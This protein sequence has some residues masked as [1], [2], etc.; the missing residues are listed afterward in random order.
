MRLLFVKE[1]M[2]WPRSSGHDIRTFYLPQAM[3]RR[4]HAV[5]LATIVPPLREAVADGGFA[6]EYCFDD[7]T[8]PVPTAAAFPMNLSNMQEK[9]CGYW[10][11]DPERVRWAAAAVADFRA[12]AVVVVGLNGLPFLGALPTGVAKIWYAADE[13]VWH[14]LSQLRPLRKSTWGELK[15][16][17]IKG[18]YQR[19]YRKLLDRVW[20]VSPADAKA[21]RWFAGIRR[22]DVAPNG[23]D[24]EH[25]SPGFERQIPNSCVFWGR[26]DFGPNIQAVEWFVKHVWP[27]VR[28]AVPNATFQLY[29][30]QS[31]PGIQALAGRDGIALGMDLPDIRA[32]VRS[33]QVVVL[34]FVSG[35]GIKNKL[36]EA[37]ALGMPI[38]AARRVVAGLNGQPPISTARTPGDWAEQLVTL[39]QS[40]E[41]RQKLGRDARAWVTEHHTWDA[42]ARIALAGLAKSADKY[43][44][45]GTTRV[46]SAAPSVPTDLSTAL[47][48][49][50][51][52]DEF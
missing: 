3:A 14:H 20:V 17:I 39:W 34:P 18:L 31:T 13:C 44:R 33:R 4:G 12:D 22:I 45:I 38:L 46:T 15:P 11:I 10:G 47:P 6:A 48:S 23:V 30:F 1:R 43:P 28:R 41:A 49:P 26:L 19:A 52:Q 9:F 32:A 51:G 40:P 24:A 7:R 8:L 2:A 50:S 37:A 29:G 5:A 36:L 35:G 25:Y 21:F 27:R 16:A 42:A